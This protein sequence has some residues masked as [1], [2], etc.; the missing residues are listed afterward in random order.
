MPKCMKKN[1][2]TGYMYIVVDNFD[3][4]NNYYRGDEFNKAKIT[5]INES[6]KIKRDDEHIDEQMMAVYKLVGYVAVPPP[7]TSIWVPVKK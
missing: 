5:A 4:N 3:D 2:T 6:N 1:I 7:S